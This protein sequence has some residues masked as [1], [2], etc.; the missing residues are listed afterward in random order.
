MMH[1]SLCPMR[2]KKRRKYLALTENGCTMLDVVHDLFCDD[3][4][5]F[6][7]GISFMVD[8]PRLFDQ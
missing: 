8:L 3:H 2:V 1:N 4:W 6:V 7:K 5:Q